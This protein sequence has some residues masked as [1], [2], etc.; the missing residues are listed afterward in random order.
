MGLHDLLQRQ[1][2][3]FIVAV[4]FVTNVIVI[5]LVP[6]NVQECEQ[7]KAPRTNRNTK[8]PSHHDLQSENIN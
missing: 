7:M 1:L 3:R 8:W 4:I 2:Y 6:L 5:V